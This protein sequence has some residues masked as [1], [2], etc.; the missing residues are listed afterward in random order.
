MR[1]FLNV[2]FLFFLVFSVTQVT[3]A[4]DFNDV[5]ANNPYAES[6]QYLSDQGVVDG[7]A[8][9]S[10]LPYDPINRAEFTK[11][12]VQYLYPQFGE[13]KYCFLDVKAEWYAPYICYAKNLNIVSGYSGDLFLPGSPINLAEAL[14]IVLES[15]EVELT[16]SSNV[17]YEKY[18]FYAVNNGL[19][20]NL[21]TDV[22]HELSRGEMVQFIYN[23]VTQD[24]QVEVE[25]YTYDVSSYDFEGGFSDH[26][27]SVGD[28]LKVSDG[29]NIRIDSIEKDENPSYGS[30]VRYSI[31]GEKDNQCSLIS[32]TGEFWTELDG[33]DFR[34]F[35]QSFVELLQV[36]DDSVGLRMYYGEKAGDRCLEMAGWKEDIA[37]S[38]YPRDDFAYSKSGNFQ[39]FFN[40]SDNLELVGYYLTAFNNC[41]D[42]YVEVFPEL[43][44]ISPFDAYWKIVPDLEGQ[45]VFSTDYER[46]TIPSYVISSTVS[47]EA[48]DHK[49]PWV[50]GGLCPVYESVLT[51]ELAHLLFATTVLQDVYDGGSK[52]EIEYVPGITGFAEGF[53]NFMEYFVLKDLAGS[54]SDSWMDYQIDICGKDG[55]IKDGYDADQLQ[56]SEVLA[57]K[58]AYASIRYDAG[59]CFYKRVEDDCGSGAIHELVERAI[60]YAGLVDEHSTMFT[61]LAD[62][63]GN[64]AVE[65]I[66]DDFGFDLQLLEIN[67][68]HPNTGFPNGLDEVGCE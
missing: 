23:L 65:E 61:Y 36:G 50:D 24:D 58:G 56:Y 27:L 31:W 40:E 55:I 66:M 30:L 49:L 63:C 53:A 8:D 21:N 1:C 28:T 62:Y 3:Y 15:Y 9:G 33:Y 13:E 42:R 41:Y 26:T 25:S 57:G 32:S 67:Q 6:I 18:Y 22:N 48:I 54:Q 4:K 60:D 2:L 7:Y 59:F 37:C 46:L 10:F 12:L 52:A 20:H 17:W 47:Q 29:F 44:K 35:T 51:H 11:I 68:K 14:K 16:F 34:E 38:F 5:Y 39:M 45:P 19:L 43:E 64:G